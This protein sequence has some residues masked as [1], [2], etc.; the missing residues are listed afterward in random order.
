MDLT[1]PH[2]RDQLKRWEASLRD[3]RVTPDPRATDRKAQ[4]QNRW[5]KFDRLF[6]KDL[7]IAPL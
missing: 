4:L 2:L 3:E 6:L 5:A 7:G 1:D